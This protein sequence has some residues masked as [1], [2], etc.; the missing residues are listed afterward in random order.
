MSNFRAV[1]VALFFFY[2]IV[3]FVIVE[4]VVVVVVVVII[5]ISFRSNLPLLLDVFLCSCLLY[6][7][8]I[9]FANR[10]T[11]D[12]IKYSNSISFSI[13]D[14]KASHCVYCC[15]WHK[16]FDSNLVSMLQLYHW[17]PSSQ[18]SY[19]SIWC[20]IL[21]SM[22]IVH[23]LCLSCGNI[24]AFSWIIIGIL[25]LSDFHIR[26]G[27]FFFNLTS[28]LL[29]FVISQDLSILP[30]IYCCC[31]KIIY[32]ISLNIIMTPCVTYTYKYL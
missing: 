4:F 19:I 22:C 1:A 26:F 29:E 16:T 21:C 8:A 31:H 14:F 18:L 20:L 25:V 5:I 28:E 15:H 27:F 6:C 11:N 32:C 3:F 23:I 30:V 9:G 12:T 13:V 17:T 2:S 7:I 24:A 10:I